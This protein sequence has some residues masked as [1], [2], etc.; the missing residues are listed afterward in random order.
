MK[1]FWT[2]WKPMVITIATVFVAAAVST[3]AAD[4]MNIKG[5]WKDIALA[6]LTA[7]LTWAANSVNPAY[8]LYGVGSKP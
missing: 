6:G 4:Q 3:A 2:R 1:A 8:S 7:V 5:D